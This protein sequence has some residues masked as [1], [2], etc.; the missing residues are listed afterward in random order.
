MEPKVALAERYELLAPVDGGEP[1]VSF[2]ARDHKTRQMVIVKRFE[3][4]R[5]PAGALARY[6]NAVALLKRSGVPGLVLPLDVVTAG[7]D[8]FAVYS[9]LLGGSV[10]QLISRGGPFS[11]LQAVDT[12]TRCASVLSATLAATGQSHRALN[13]SNLW[14]SPTGEV[15]I[16]DFGIAEFG[17]HAV[18]PRGER[19]FVE[20]RA[21]EQ[22]DGG[23]GDAR[24]DVFMLGVLLYELS[25]GIHPFSGSSAFHAA[26]HLLST[27]PPSAA[28]IRGMSQGG[29]REAEKLLVR[30]LARAPAERFAGAQE[31]LLAL[32][33]ARRVIGSPSRLAQGAAAPAS[34]AP[35][36]RPAVIVEDP[37]TIIQPPGLGA[38]RR[39][40]PSQAPAAALVTA[41]A[42]PASSPPPATPKSASLPQPSDLSASRPLQPA[43]SHPVLLT[44]PAAH[45]SRPRDL[46]PPEQRSQSAQRL[47]VLP[48]PLCER[49]EVLPSTSPQTVREH[50]TERDVPNHL[51]GQEEPRTALFTRSVAGPATPEAESTL[52]WP[53]TAI[54]ADDS[55]TAAPTLPITAARAAWPAEEGTLILPQDHTASDAPPAISNDLAMTDPRP[56]APS[57]TSHAHTILIVLNVVCIVL[58]LG[59]VLLTLIR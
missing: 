36:A 41:P 52:M 54:G 33:C 34:N 39:A 7:A 25:T 19:V 16:L 42:I 46:A 38:R 11:W 12:V 27:P 50:I 45:T 4:T 3:L 49:T 5:S 32:D 51:G 6:A 48:T 47:S 53:N 24:T 35:L 23:P 22:I 37:T 20:Y 55:P 31:F 30:A 43:S 17:V 29:A 26:R 2:H 15:S 21:P 8:P 40:A 57:T 59:G 9:P 58:V 56:V 1:A 14:L 18:P 28:L 13:P 44:A 10:A